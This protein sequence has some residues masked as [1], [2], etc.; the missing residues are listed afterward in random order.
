MAIGALAAL[1]IILSLPGIALAAITGVPFLKNLLDFPVQPILAVL[2]VFI[3]KRPFSATLWAGLFA[4]IG[5]PLPFLAPP[6]FFLKVPYAMLFGLTIDLVWFLTKRWEKVSS[7]I[8]GT[9]ILG[10]GIP[11]AVLFWTI[12]GVPELAAAAGKFLT[13]IFVPLMIIVGGGLGYVGWLIYK[14]IEKTAVVR[15]IQQG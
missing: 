13:F 10:L 2:V 15:R 4:I 6:G 9:T 3:I 14:R 12:L 11:L 1:R 8:I 7:M 5:L